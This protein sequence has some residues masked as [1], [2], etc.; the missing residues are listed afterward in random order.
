MIYYFRL[1]DCR[2]VIIM[3]T[4]RKVRAFKEHG[5]GEIPVEA[6][7]RKVQQKITTNL[8][9]GKGEKVRQELTAPLVTRVAM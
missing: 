1:P 5:A 9:I 2:R 6:T 8:M 3:I 4:V 7:L